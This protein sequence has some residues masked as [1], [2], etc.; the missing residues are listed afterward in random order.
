MIFVLV[1]SA[2]ILSLSPTEAVTCRESQLLR[3]IMSGADHNGQSLNRIGHDSLFASASLKSTNIKYFWG[4][5]DL[6]RLSGSI[7]AG[8]QKRKCS[9]LIVGQ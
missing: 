6:R 4:L 9:D 3:L 2:A 8:K 7:A 1:M 5:K